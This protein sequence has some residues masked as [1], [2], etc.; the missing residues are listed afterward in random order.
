MFGYILPCSK[1]LLGI[2]DNIVV[3]QF[4]AILAKPYAIFRTTALFL[5]Q[6]GIVPWAG[7]G[8]T[9]DVSGNSEIDGFCRIFLRTS[10]IGL[11]I[12]I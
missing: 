12:G 1:D 9:R 3:D 7:R 2:A 10:R 5:G 8:C 6:I 11:A 4:R